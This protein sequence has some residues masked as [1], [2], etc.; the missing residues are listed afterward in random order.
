[1]NPV[2]SLIQ[3]RN[4]II[5]LIKL[6]DFSHRPNNKKRNKTFACT[7]SINNTDNDFILIR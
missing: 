6:L 7:V 5:A 2:I 1:M 4:F 3:L